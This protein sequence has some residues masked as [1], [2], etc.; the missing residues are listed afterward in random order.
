VL[1]GKGDA[2][3]K[4]LVPSIRRGQNKRRDRGALELEPVSGSPAPKKVRARLRVFP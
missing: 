1:Y 4:T 2:A 3:R